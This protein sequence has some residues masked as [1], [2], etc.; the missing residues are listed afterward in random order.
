MT[1]PAVSFNI[2]NVFESFVYIL[3]QDLHPGIY[4]GP[5]IAADELADCYPDKREKVKVLDI[6]CGTGL[7]GEEVS[8]V[9]NREYICDPFREKRPYGNCE[10]YRPWSACARSKLFAY[11]R[12]SIILHN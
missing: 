6:A 11:G 3:L 4:N 9:F 12:F 5:S 10:K 8:G 2:W 7:V 1:D